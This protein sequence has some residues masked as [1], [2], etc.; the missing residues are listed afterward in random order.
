MKNKD[1]LSTKYAVNIMCPKYKE[2]RART[3]EKKE[4]QFE[5][6]IKVG[7]ELFLKKGFEGFSMR[8]LAE[9]LHMTKNNLYN[10]VSS[11]RE[12]WIAIRNKFYNQFKTENLEII[13]NHQGSNTELIL[14]IS[15]H[16]IE[17]A[18]RDH[19]VFLMM[20]APTNA[21]PSKGVGKI[22]KK[23]R[24]YRLLDGT[25]K[26]VQKTIDSGEIGD[27]NP[28]L[29]SLLIFSLLFGSTYIDFNRRVLN[30]VLENVQLSVKD[31]SPEEFQ[32]YIISIIE[33]L[34]TNDLV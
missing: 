28:A 2:T 12:L 26:L 30:P 18:E 6:I 20:F 10:Y 31:I 22:E 1:L 29:I 14:E 32:N 5:R 15:K 27:K 3:P 7:T 13:K 19:D 8:N 24:E 4:D 9:D 33:K 23:Y 34:L 16:F 11:K 25:T 21:P 17:F